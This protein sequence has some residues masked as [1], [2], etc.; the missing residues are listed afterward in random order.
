MIDEHFMRQWN[1][2]HTALSAD[3]D[4]RLAQIAQRL[5]RR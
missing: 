1:E 4:R 2:G 5:S 3:I